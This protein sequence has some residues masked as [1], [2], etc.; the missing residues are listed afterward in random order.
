MKSVQLI[1][2]LVN[3]IQVSGIDNQICLRLLR[4][5]VCSEL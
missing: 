1:E 2:Q 3:S 4:L 5:V